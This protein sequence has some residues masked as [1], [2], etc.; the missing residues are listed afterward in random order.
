M[1]KNNKFRYAIITLDNVNAIG[2]YFNKLG[3]DGWELVAVNAGM[4]FFKRGRST[5]LNDDITDYKKY[6]EKL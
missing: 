4:A 2:P 3:N 1:I 5:T 6:L